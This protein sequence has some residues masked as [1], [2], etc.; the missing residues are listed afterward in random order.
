MR[1][2]PTLTK[3]LRSVLESGRDAMRYF[4]GPLSDAELRERLRPLWQRFGSRVTKDFARRHPGQ[5][6]ACW[7]WFEAPEPRPVAPKPNG[8]YPKN[9]RSET[10]FRR[11][12]TDVT[13]S[14]M[15]C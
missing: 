11:S 9:W 15:G 8:S 12:W 1:K 5:R 13:W 14:S 3:K 7:W 6:P 2:R 10:F 4:D